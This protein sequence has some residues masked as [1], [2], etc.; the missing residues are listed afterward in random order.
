MTA[1]PFL[2]VEH[3]ATGRRW[4]G[5]GPEVER[6]G[7]AIAQTHELPE[8]VGRV[9][10]ARGV[11]PETAADYLNP[12]LRALMPDPSVLAGMDTAAQRL[13]AAVVKGERIAVFG[14]YD[15]D[16]GASVALLCTWFGLL[17]RSATP[18]IPD[19]IDEG[20]G[21]NVPA[22]AALA[23]DHDL[24]LC[25]DCG[26][27][28][29]E[30]V[31]AARAEGADVIIADH[32][33]AQENLPDALAVVNPNRHDDG[34]D[35]GYLC[36]A[37][38]VFLLL[39]ATNRELRRQGGFGDR[40]EPDL[41]AL[42]DLVAV[43]T[44]ADVAPL[45]GLNR[46]LVRQGLAVLARRARPGL[47]ALADV[48]GLRAPPTSRDLGFALGPRIN[49]GGR[50]GKADLGQRLLTTADPHEAAALAEK[51]NLLNRERQEIEA[52]VL[53][54]AIAQA[55]AGDVSAP[56]VW[57]AGEGWHPGVVGIVASR[58]KD[59]FNRP[60]VVIGLDGSQGKGSG[61]SVPG[62][63]LGSAVAAL[64]RQGLLLKGGG[65]VMAAGLTVEQGALDEAMAA[66]GVALAAQG[67]GDVGP[68][69]LRLDGALA[70]GGATVDL[71][72]RLEA[73]GPFGQANPAPRLAFGSV[74][75]KGVRTVGNGHCQLRLAGSGGPQ[76]AAIAFRAADSGLAALFEAAA[77]SGTPLHIAGRLEIDD[78]G[79]RRKPKLRVEDAAPVA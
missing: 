37:G 34:S 35:L 51:L 65:H 71:V 11:V 21:P 19:R 57:A 8:I 15:V 28:S 49:A 54:A 67:A 46:A 29:F 18:Y 32:H 59:R 55:E 47:A 14:D 78:W 27:L 39:V 53:E 61:R 52:V 6:L 23:R 72:E 58:L 12:T 50:V 75:V 48:A 4:V 73:A 42:L 33:L 9:L 45:V 31:A 24:I 69:D 68:A 64:V 40:G 60:A 5:P 16:G 74:Q 30:P 56:L 43:A 79:G 44:V 76:L 10:A 26:T 66:L 63:D 70:P 62:V 1:P 22:M 20:Y 41:M 38:V 25:V 77:A 2:N 17:G 7:L 3:S 36:A 13:A